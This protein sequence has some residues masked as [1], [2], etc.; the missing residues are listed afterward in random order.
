MPN[1]LLYLYN[2]R[3]K[4][5][6]IKSKFDFNFYN[7]NVIEN[8]KLCSSV[9]DI[10]RQKYGEIEEKLCH[11]IKNNEKDYYAHIFRFMCEIKDAEGD[12]HVTLYVDQLFSALIRFNI[13]TFV[14]AFSYYTKNDLQ[15][16]NSFQFVRILFNS[17]F[18]CFEFYNLINEHDYT[19]KE[20]I[21]HFFFV[22][23]PEDEITQDIFLLFDEFVHNCF[24]Q[25]DF[26][27]PDEY[28]KYDSVFLELK[29]D[30]SADNAD[31]IIQYLSKTLIENSGNSKIEFD[32]HFCIDYSKY[33]ENNFSLLKGCY[34]YNL[35]NNSN[36]DF[37]YLELKCLCIKDKNFLKEYFEWRISNNNKFYED[38]STLS[39]IWELDY[40]YDDIEKLIFYLVEKCGF[41]CWEPISLLFSSSNHN[42][43]NFI[44]EFITQ[45]H[46]DVELMTIIFGIIRE[47]YPY[48]VFINFLECFL[49]L[50]KSKGDFEKVVSFKLYL[51]GLFSEEG[52]LKNDLN[53]YKGIK[54][55][56]N[57]LDSID[58]LG[59]IVV[60][61]DKIQGI[62]I[63]LK[64][65]NDE[66]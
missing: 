36:H 63:E 17:E 7:E 66:E 55:M 43:E 21:K 45:N 42:E 25:F 32:T 35:K 41:Y 47:K 44:K 48:D 3:L 28:L 34:F 51:R 62:G 37:D 2:E 29:E 58:Y 30:L 56:L 60:I 54:D 15:L 19:E 57:G 14:D 61:N 33:F 20:R 18:D 13:E 22:N 8:I 46:D 1:K 10:R 38:N 53:L 49:K 5:C 26:W 27:N 9:F 31:N 24:E 64:N 16:L 4:K 23:F 65:L 6:N 39:F 52:D 50:N 40:N 11:V 12:N 59:H